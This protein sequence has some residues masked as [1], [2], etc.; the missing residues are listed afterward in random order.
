M[1]AII[2]AA[3]ILDD[4]HHSREGGW[5]QLTKAIGWAHQIAGQGF[6]FSDAVYIIGWVNCLLLVRQ[7]KATSL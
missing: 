1:P 2:D 6:Y 7:N 3:H 5:F 4:S